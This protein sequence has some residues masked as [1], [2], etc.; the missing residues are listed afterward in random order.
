MEEEIQDKIR[1]KYNE[2][3]L[4]IEVSFKEFR[5]YIIEGTLLFR[6]AIGFNFLYKYDSN[7][8]IENNIFNIEKIIDNFIIKICK[9]KEEK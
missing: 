2:E 9:Y 1:K 6:N 5:N 3:I 4:R 8:S 7:M